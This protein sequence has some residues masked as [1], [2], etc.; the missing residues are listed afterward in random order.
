[1]QRLYNGDVGVVREGD[2]GTLRAFF[3]EASGRVRA[4][5]LSRLPEHEPAYALTVHKSQGSEFQE[6]VLVLPPEPVR[7]L[8]RELLYTGITR[9]RERI[10]VWGREAVVCSAIATVT[11]RRSGLRDA[12][13]GR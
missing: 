11:E 6:V 8:T 4:V 12:L 7:V 10:E 5:P 3:A 2:D 9:A 13:W 1:V